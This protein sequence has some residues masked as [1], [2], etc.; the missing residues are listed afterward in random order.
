MELNV[1]QT[2]EPK[3]LEAAFALRRQVWAKLPGVNAQSALSGGLDDGMDGA[4]L[5]W[6]VVAGGS[7]V[8]S[9]RLCVCAS[10]DTLPDANVFRDSP[11][12]V[13][14]P[15][16]AINRLVVHPEFRGLGVASRLDSVRISEARIRGCASVTACWSPFSGERRRCALESLGFVPVHGGREHAAR[17][18]LR[19]LIGFSLRF[20]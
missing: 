7:V 16:S 20:S 15:T 4:G 6:V 13:P 10:L 9:A 19:C 8:A 5:H 14:L 17:E 3:L 18:P 11:A 2:T 1:F 12:E